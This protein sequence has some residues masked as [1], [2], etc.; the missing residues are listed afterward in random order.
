MPYL[1]WFFMLFLLQLVIF[2]KYKVISGQTIRYSVYSLICEAY[3]LWSTK[4]DMTPL[5]LGQ[6]FCL[7]LAK[8]MELVHQIHLAEE[9]PTQAG[10]TVKM[11]VMSTRHAGAVVTSTDF[12]IFFLFWEK[13]APQCQCRV[14]DLFWWLA[15][16]RAYVNE[17][18][19][20]PASICR[21]TGPGL[22][23]NTSLS[24]NHGLLP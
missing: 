7:G 24:I 9:G 23:C 2:I 5:G 12:W 11:S 10:K 17:N 1:S 3:W 22:R 15:K 13:I 14:V 19:S 6:H 21:E 20:I 18:W 4:L 8:F 16:L